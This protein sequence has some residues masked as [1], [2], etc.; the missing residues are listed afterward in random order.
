VPCWSTINVGDMLESQLSPRQLILVH[1]ECREFG[2]YSPMSS[3]LNYSQLGH[4]PQY[5]QVAIIGKSGCS[6]SL[7][8]YHRIKKSNYLASHSISLPWTC[9]EKA[10]LQLLSLHGQ[11][12]EYLFM[13]AKQHHQQAWKKRLL[14]HYWP[15]T[16]RT[17]S[18]ISAY[19]VWPLV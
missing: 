6:V 10:N 9:P 11:T 2:A 19:A 14:W 4:S 8:S 16:L 5:S 13:T 12:I 3:T 18:S 7:E 15:T 17:E 1:Q